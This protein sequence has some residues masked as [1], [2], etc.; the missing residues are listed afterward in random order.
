[1]TGDATDAM[2]DWKPDLVV[3][4]PTG[5]PG[6]ADMVLQARAAGVEVIEVK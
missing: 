5:G 1:M 6:G 3:V 2:L 4:F